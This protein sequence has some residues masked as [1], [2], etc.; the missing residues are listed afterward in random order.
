MGCG[1]LQSLATRGFSN[2]PTTE[3][4]KKGGKNMLNYNNLMKRHM[5]GI[6]R[7]TNGKS[8]YENY[9]EDCD[10]IR[11]FM[12]EIQQEQ[13]DREYRAYIDKHF[14]KLGKTIEKSIE[15]SFKL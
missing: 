15:K 11:E 7:A 5:A 3:V 6:R 9:A 1:E 14:E 8:A 4:Q 10:E 12:A 13:E 2:Y